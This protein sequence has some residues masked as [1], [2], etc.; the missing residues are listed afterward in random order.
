ML[1]TKQII[2]IKDKNETRKAGDILMD[3]EHTKLIVLQ[4]TDGRKVSFRQI[5]AIRLEGKLYC[6]M[7]P[8]TPIR[9]LEEMSGLIFEVEHDRFILIKDARKTTRVFESY[10]K[11]INGGA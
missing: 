10:Y 9:G 11:N 1:R 4:N 6:L 8:L 5:Y 3:K 7:N 2:V